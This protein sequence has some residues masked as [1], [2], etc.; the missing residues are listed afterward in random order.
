MGR[1]DETDALPE[2]PNAVELNA[3]RSKI[4]LEDVSFNYKNE[5]KTVV[6]DLNLTIPKGQMVALV[7][8]S[9]GGKS[10]LIKLIQ[11]LYD[12]TAGAIF[13]DE[14]DLRDARISSLKR[15]IALVTQ[16][17]VL[18]NDTVRYNI[19]YGKPGASDE[20]VH[21]AARIAFAHEFVAELPPVRTFVRARPFCGRSTPAIAIARAVWSTRRF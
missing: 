10:S 1:F 8:E 14:I 13:W 16:E 17:T 4:T 20:E 19:S 11:R 15:Q 12:P 5:N 6:R 7:G 9:G 18:F 3:L 21:E 2:K